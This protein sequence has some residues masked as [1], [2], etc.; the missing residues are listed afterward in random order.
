MLKQKQGS[1]PSEEKG[2]AV[3][4]EPETPFDTIEGSHEYVALLA[5]ALAE[6]RREV[7][8]EIASA[9]RDGAQRRKDA[10]VLVSYNLAKLNLHITTSRRILNDL[11]TLRRLL[12]EEREARRRPTE[13]PVAFRA[14]A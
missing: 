6:A 3:G 7:D 14:R 5:E 12:L 11:R 2:L 1:H 10:L 13:Q 4:Y 8:A 9:D